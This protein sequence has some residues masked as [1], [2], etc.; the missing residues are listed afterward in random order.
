MLFHSLCVCFSCVF[1]AALCLFVVTFVLTVRVAGVN[2]MANY[3]QVLHLIRYKNWHTE[4]LFDRKFKLVCSELNGR[5][6]S[7]DFKV[8]VRPRPL[9]G[10]DSGAFTAQEWKEVLA[11]HLSQTKSS[12]FVVNVV[13]PFLTVCR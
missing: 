12:D 5:Y 10:C 13:P 1:S 3:E 9:P 7:N 4:A 11:E 2:S 8:E 6:I